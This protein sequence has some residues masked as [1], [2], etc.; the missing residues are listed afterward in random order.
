MTKSAYLAKLRAIEAGPPASDAGRLF[1]ELV[2]EPGLPRA[3][4]ASRATRFH[5]D[6]EQIVREVGSLRP[7]AE[8]Q[9]LQDR[10]VAA[11]RE[12]VAAVARAARAARAGTLSCGRQMNSRIYGLPSTRRAEA[13]LRLLAKKGYVI[14]LNASD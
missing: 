7:P 9:R 3:E 14:G 4:C 6:L 5:A 8:V 2:V 11:A 1:F 12:S 10:F 13:V